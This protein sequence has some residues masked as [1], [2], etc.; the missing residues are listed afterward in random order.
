MGGSPKRS[1]SVLRN[2]NYVVVEGKVTKRRFLNR[3]LL[4]WK[5]RGVV[6]KVS[7]WLVF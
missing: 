4:H 1:L 2:D 6:E 7:D 5:K 3:N